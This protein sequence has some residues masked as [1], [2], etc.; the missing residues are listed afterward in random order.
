[1]GRTIEEIEIAID[2]EPQVPHSQDAHGLFEVPKPQIPR[3]DHPIRLHIQREVL[4][5]EPPH[6]IEVDISTG[7][8]LLD[9]L[10]MR[11][12]D[13]YALQKGVVVEIRLR[14]STLGKQVNQSMKSIT[15]INAN[16]Q[17]TKKK[18]REG[19][20]SKKKLESIIN[21][22]CSNL[23]DAELLQEIP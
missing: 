19:D 15:K 13:V 6:S 23:E 4:D 5:L 18:V 17:R 1:M 9:F 20:K 22:A 16:M 10:K 12:M 11:L 14:G 3:G 7:H 8:I 21:L 2:H